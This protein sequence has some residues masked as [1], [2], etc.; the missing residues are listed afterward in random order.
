MVTPPKFTD[1]LP[2]E[3]QAFPIAIRE[4]FRGELLNFGGELQDIKNDKRTF[5]PT[6]NSLFNHLQKLPS[7]EKKRKNNETQVYNVKKTSS[8]PPATKKNLGQ[9]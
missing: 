4:L 1:S 3:R 2:P 7:T 5:P 8:L 6:P 9:F